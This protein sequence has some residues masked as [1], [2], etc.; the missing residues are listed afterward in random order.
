MAVKTQDAADVD[1]WETSTI[2]YPTVET[3]HE[4]SILKIVKAPAPDIS[5]EINLRAQQLARRAVAV[6][7]PPSN[8][9]TTAQC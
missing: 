4:D 5:D 1:S 6:S 2:A 8:F 7:T 9:F 3:I